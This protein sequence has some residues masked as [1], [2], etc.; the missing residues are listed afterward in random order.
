MTARMPASQ[1]SLWFKEGPPAAGRDPRRSLPGCRAV[2]VGK[3]AVPSSARGR[4]PRPRVGVT[5]TRGSD[6]HAGRLERGLCE[7]GRFGMVPFA[8]ASDGG[9]ST[10]TPRGSAASSVTSRR[11]VHPHP[12]RARSHG[13]RARAL[14]TTVDDAALLLDLASGP[15]TETDAPCP[16][17]SRSTPGDPH[18][19]RAHL[20][21]RGRSTSGCDRRPRVAA[22][23]R[24]AADVPSGRPARRSR[25]RGVVPESLDVTAPGRSTTDRP[26]RRPL[27]ERPTSWIRR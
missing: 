21:R 13:R 26:P 10:R 4:T 1:G 12:G 14:A 24:S 11:S 6:P 3:T 16:R 18:A 15:T 25:S 22:I 9:G 23:T 20:R 5:R 2:P 7:C 8:T 19:E 17:P 27:A